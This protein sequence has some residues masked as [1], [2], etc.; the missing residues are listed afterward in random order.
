[1]HMDQNSN[2]LITRLR[3]DRSFLNAHGFS[4]GK[5]VLYV[6]NCMQQMAAYYYSYNGRRPSQ[7]YTT[8]ALYIIIGQTATCN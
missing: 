7:K 3:V 8:D 4:I 6:L 5:S 1:M 2:K